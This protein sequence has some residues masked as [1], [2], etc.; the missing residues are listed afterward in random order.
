MKDVNDYVTIKY[1]YKW[2]HFYKQ[3]SPDAEMKK[4]SSYVEGQLFFPFSGHQ[5]WWEI[6]GA[7]GLWSFLKPPEV[8]HQLTF[9]RGKK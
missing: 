9:A 7:N 8:E 1:V 2:C 6:K 4:P 5:S 3:V